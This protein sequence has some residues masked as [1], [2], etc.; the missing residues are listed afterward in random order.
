MIDDEV[1]GKRR[2]QGLKAVDVGSIDEQ[3]TAGVGNQGDQLGT[4][5]W[6]PTL[7]LPEGAKAILPDGE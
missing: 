1:S 5:R 4:D 7:I 3:T 2:W 6:K